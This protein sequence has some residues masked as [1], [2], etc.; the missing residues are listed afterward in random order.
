MDL[1]GWTKN[2]E[3]NKNEENLMRASLTLN[4]FT[5]KILKKKFKKEVYKF[6]RPM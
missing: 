4:L 5:H 6:F 1:Y 3:N 2:I